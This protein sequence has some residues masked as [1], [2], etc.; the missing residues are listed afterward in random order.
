MTAAGV[1]VVAH[2]LT[3]VVASTECTALSLLVLVYGP[4]AVVVATGLTVTESW[5]NS[6]VSDVTIE[7]HWRNGARSIFSY[8][9]IGVSWGRDEHVPPSLP[10]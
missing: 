7:D 5:R 4:A 6:D 1:T 3:A 8:R 10:D 2:T 9:D